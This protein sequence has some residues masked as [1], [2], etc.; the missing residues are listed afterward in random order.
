MKYDFNEI[1]QRIV[2][3]KWEY[4]SVINGFL[5]IFMFVV[6]ID[7]VFFV[8]VCQVLIEVCN[9]R[10]FGYLVYYDDFKDVLV[11]WYD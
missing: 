2:L 7:L 1:Y 3:E 10:E 8:E 9:C 4:D 6:D 11:F 5:V